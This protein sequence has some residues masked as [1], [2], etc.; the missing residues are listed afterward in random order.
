MLQ[1]QD[2][3]AAGLYD[4]PEEVIREALRSLT[5]VHPEYKIKIAVARYRQG[6]LSIAKAAQIAGVSGEQ[7][8]D[9]LWAHVV[10]PELGPAD[11][12]EVREEVEVLRGYLDY[13]SPVVD[14]GELFEEEG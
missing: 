8:K 3:M 2:F 7:M 11:V 1:V 14:L 10:E 12:Q 13:R 6:M 5:Q 4:S 9:L